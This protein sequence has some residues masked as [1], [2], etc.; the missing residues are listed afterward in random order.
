LKGLS[1]RR[2]KQGGIHGKGEA[3]EKDQDLETFLR[4]HADTQLASTIMAL[5]EGSASLARRI[6]R[7]GLDSDYDAAAGSANSGGEAQYALDLFADQQ[8][9]Q[10]LRGGGV[11]ILV[12]EERDQPSV[13]DGDGELLVAID[14][15][16]G[17]SNIG[18]NISIGSIFSVMDAT[19]TD[20][21]R[22]MQKGDAQL[23]AGFALY[24]PQT[25][26]LFTTG[27]GVHSAILDPDDGRFKMFRTGLRIPADLA[28][29]AI[30]TANYRHW[31]P[32][33]RA[34]FD[35]CVLGADGPRRKNFNMRW[36]GSMVAD[37]Y[38]I[39][40]RG[41]VYLYPEDAR[42]GYERGRL[43]LVY[44]ANPVAFL[45]EQAGGAAID[46]RNRILDIHPG[47]IHSR[48]P[49]IFGS[50]DEVEQIARY[51]RAGEHT[52][53]RSPLFNKRGLLRQ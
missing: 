49:L 15:L 48:C 29:F 26:F 53:E 38:R 8:F 41:G 40:M 22:L 11:R 43:R 46:G 7:G 10:V 17:S 52:A 45:I 19:P 16:D 6:N 5:S 2:K 36:I 32:P 34:Y 24:G 31:R 3:L 13:L 47:D 50:R 23:A 21:G 4:E 28:E 44:E 33:V 37:A 25:C 51:Y 14:P 39:L 12:S 35:D 18:A 27:D 42:Q 1:R 9:S 30:N 20:G